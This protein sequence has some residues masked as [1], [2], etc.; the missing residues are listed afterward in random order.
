MTL[1]RLA[2]AAAVVAALVVAAF[3]RLDALGEP[4]YWLDEILHQQIT[5]DVATLPWW[6]WFGTLHAEHAGLYYLTQLATRLFGTSEAAGRSAAALL[7]I[8]TILVAWLVVRRARGGAVAATVA[9]VLLAVSPLHVYFSREA[10]SYALLTLLAAALML[11]LLRGRSLVAAIALLAGM[12]YT[13]GVSATIVISAFLV[14]AL[15]ALLLREERRWY[16]T[17]AGCCLVTL[18]LFR[19]V[20]GARPV[21]DAQWPGFPTIDLQF[22]TSLART[23]SVSA[24]AS[25]ISGRTAVAMLLFALAGA[26]ALARGERREAI[27]VIGM[28]VLPLVVSLV[29]LKTLDHF[30]AARYV[31]PAVFGYCVL[32]G[33]GV[34]W[35]ARLLFTPFGR[36]RDALAAVLALATLWAT[37]A[38]MWPSARREP[39]LKLDWRAVAKTIARHAQHGDVV[40][41]AEPWSE[42]SLRWYLEQQ[43]Q[44]PR[45]IGATDVALVERFR[46]TET[47]WLVSA[48]YDDSPLRRWM[49]GLPMVA[50]S[51]LENLRVHY[52]SPAAN[53][54][55]RERGG[56]AEHRA[57]AAA[58][59][60][61][62]FTLRMSEGEEQFFGEGWAMSEG[63][64]REAFRWALG[65]RAVVTFPRSTP[66]DR[67]VR[68]NVLPFSHPSL[69]PQSVRVLV[70][71]YAV[72]DVTLAPRWDERAL[73]IPAHFWLEGWNTLTFDFARAHAP[74]TLD[75]RA[76]DHR[77]LAVSFESISVDD[78][79]AP[80][81]L[82][83]DAPVVALPHLAALIDQKT[84]WRRGETRLELARLDRDKVAALLGRLGVDPEA[85][86]P[87]VARGELRL[88]QLAARI[89]YGQ[90]CVD[91]TTFL[92]QA[93]ALLLERPFSEIER[94]D[95]FRRIREGTPRAEIAAR[96]VRST[97]F[98]KKY[99]R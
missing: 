89:A 58:Q 16:A 98:A 80:R 66:R 86:W 14:A 53:D 72:G 50:A 61:R 35:L 97:D 56:P 69:P 10:R 17:V 93:F 96:I 64:G 19:L 75:P 73:A 67:V 4:S 32:A 31:M 88:E 84:L 81:S 7:G 43:S 28:T 87:R 1:S 54:V 26:I 27:V 25:E 90:D 62:G 77:P 57:V 20:Y 6:R 52:S 8:C 9:A 46:R 33:I 63:G 79:G 82:E 39:F 65:K 42:V 12:L 37:A 22:F 51:T 18:A 29:V 36:W 49:C 15:C 30:Y 68:I 13:S 95:L 21:A 91:D 11:V 2:S 24:L 60:E 83:R 71:G 70:N 40:I 3:L 99:G 85:A 38:H 44:P 34:T 41:A 76:S 92:T 59:G 55:L 45:L 94:D 5:S 23:F 48:G 78:A 74:S 47:L